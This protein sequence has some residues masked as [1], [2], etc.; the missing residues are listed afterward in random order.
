MTRYQLIS[1]KE[2]APSGE[3]KK[4]SVAEL[5]SL[6]V[7]K[8]IGFLVQNG[9]AVKGSVKATKYDLKFSLEWQSAKDKLFHQQSY[10]PFVAS[11]GSIRAKASGSTRVSVEKPEAKA[12]E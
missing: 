10:V 5:Q 6:A 12:S 1:T 8:M 7:Q 11:D 4:I 9:R 2:E 3:I